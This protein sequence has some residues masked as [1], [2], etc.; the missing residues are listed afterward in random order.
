[1]RKLFK[2]IVAMT[3]AIIMMASVASMGVGAES[4]V[5]DNVGGFRTT[6]S[7][8]QTSINR[9]RI[10]TS[11]SGDASVNVAG[12]A[13]YTYNG[14]TY[15]TGNGYGGFRGTSATITKDGGSWRTLNT[16]HGVNSDSAKVSSSTWKDLGVI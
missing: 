13:T 12:T 2:R 4:V 9:I 11:V 1:M 7:A 6:C 10:S 5:F 14:K 15:T 8:S 16:T 3:G